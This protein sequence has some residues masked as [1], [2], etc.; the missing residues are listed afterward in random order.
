MTL[1]IVCGYSVVNQNLRSEI[2]WLGL[3]EDYYPTLLDS[4]EK[5]QPYCV[6]FTG[7]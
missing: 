5:N 3:T 7:G 1:A 4:L 2:E 6:V